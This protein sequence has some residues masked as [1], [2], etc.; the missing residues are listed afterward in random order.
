MN[1]M[2][3]IPRTISRTVRVPSAIH[4][5]GEVIHSHAGDPCEELRSAVVRRPEE[6]GMSAKKVGATF[7]GTAEREPILTGRG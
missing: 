4:D 1:T 5:S 6:Q 3:S 7:C 2:L